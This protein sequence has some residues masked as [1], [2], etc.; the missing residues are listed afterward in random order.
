MNKSPTQDGNGIANW[1]LHPVPQYVP[2][3][4]V[5]FAPYEPVMPQELPPTAM[6]F[7]TAQSNKM[8]NIPL[9][10]PAAVYSLNRASRI[11]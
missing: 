9:P 5:A 8:L 1:L 10:T 2:L 3:S 11:F 6:V 7:P 4:D